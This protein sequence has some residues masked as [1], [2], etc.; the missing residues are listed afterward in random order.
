V[1]F[2]LGRYECDHQGEGCTRFRKKHS[3]FRSPELATV[4]EFE[5]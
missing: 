4:T 2:S 3:D 5:V 1:D